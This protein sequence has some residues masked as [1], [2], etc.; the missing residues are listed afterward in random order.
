MEQNLFIA[1]VIITIIGIGIMY[2]KMVLIWHDVEQKRLKRMENEWR[3]VNKLYLHIVSN[4]GE[5]PIENVTYNQMHER[6]K[7]YFKYE[8]SCC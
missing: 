6:I 3:E 7:Q 4:C 8:Y 2:A 5:K 1:F